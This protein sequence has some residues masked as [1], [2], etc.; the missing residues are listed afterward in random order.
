MRQRPRRCGG[1]AAIASNYMDNASN[2]NVL[3]LTIELVPATAWGAKLR[4]VLTRQGW[5]ALRRH[6]FAQPRSRRQEAFDWQAGG[7][8]NQHR[9]RR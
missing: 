9:Q 1:S 2:S 6:V 7:V 3:R 4:D 8:A 5:D